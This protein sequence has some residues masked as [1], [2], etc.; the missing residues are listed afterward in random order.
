MTDLGTGP[1]TA[2]VAYCSQL[3]LR[4]HIAPSGNEIYK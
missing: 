4:S 1:A 3:D 2:A